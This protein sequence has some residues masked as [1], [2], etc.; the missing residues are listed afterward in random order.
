MVLRSKPDTVLPEL[1]PFFM[2][3]NFFME[4]ALSIS[5]GSLSPTINWEALAKE[6]FLLP[7]IQEQ[8]RLVET[9]L[10]LEDSLEKYRNTIDAIRSLRVALLNHHFF[11]R[12]EKGQ[13]LKDMAALKSGGTPTRSKRGFWGGELPWASGK[14]LKARELFMTEEKLTVQGWQA[15]KVAPENSSLIVVRGMI[16]A[17]TFPV[18][19]CKVPMA[20]NQD[21]RALVAGPKIRPEYL[22]M[23][24]E[25]MGPW[26]LSRTAEST[27]GT[28]RLEA[29]TLEK[30]LIPAES[31]DVQ[32]KLISENRIILEQQAAAEIRRSRLLE[33]KKKFLA[34]LAG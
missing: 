29:Q 10:A 32:E 13:P 1:L 3:S 26:F 30:A 9:C 12:L 11:S 23:W 6:E 33:M 2:Q 19:V 25:C 24:A 17:H 34:E 20:F 16:L 18:S 27:H 4:R 21:L 5:V 7:A 31:F 8:A 22:T 14:D 15:A 28:K